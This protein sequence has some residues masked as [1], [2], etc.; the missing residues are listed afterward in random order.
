MSFLEAEPDAGRT[1]R[2]TSFRPPINSDNVALSGRTSPASQSTI[3]RRHSSSSMVTE[4]SDLNEISTSDARHDPTAPP[5]NTVTIIVWHVVLVLITWAIFFL[6]TEIRDPRGRLSWMCASHHPPAI[7]TTTNT[8]FLATTT[9]KVTI[10]TTTTTTKTVESTTYV[11]AIVITFAPATAN[12]TLT[13]TSTAVRYATTTTKT[14]TLTT[15][16]YATA[17]TTETRTFISIAVTYPYTT[18]TTVKATSTVTTTATTTAAMT[19]AQ[20]TGIFDAI[21]FV[22]NPLRAIQ[23]IIVQ[24]IRRIVR[25]TV[26]STTTAPTTA[27][28][29]AAQP[30]PSFDAVHFPRTP[31][32]ALQEEDDAQQIRDNIAMMRKMVDRAYRKEGKKDSERRGPPPAHHALYTG[33][34]GGGG[35]GGGQV[36]G[37]SDDDRGGDGFFLEHDFYKR[38]GPPWSEFPRWHLFEY[39]RKLGRPMERYWRDW[40]EDQ[41]GFRRWG[42]PSDRERA[43]WEAWKHANGRSSEDEEQPVGQYLDSWYEHVVYWRDNRCM[44][45]YPY[46]WAPEWENPLEMTGKAE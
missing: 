11:T 28:I 1:R 31:W 20:P 22:I 10:P 16:A 15:T 5:A 41:M 44:Q 38:F 40:S 37:E 19:A 2:G 18:T 7:T 6:V 42:G 8:D 9:A 46:G 23:D 43:F 45:A 4:I 27:T 24:R 30:T 29:T 33:S 25:V 3:S 32:L 13:Y 14:N 21:L 26:T 39:Y 17:T 12:E 35:G 36:S 34:G